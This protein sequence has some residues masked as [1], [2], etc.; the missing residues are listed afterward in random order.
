[1]QI[2]R[3]KV[4]ATR[5]LNEKSQKKLSVAHIDLEAHSFLKITHFVN[6]YLANVLITNSDPIVFTS[7]QAILAT[8]KIA[9]AFGIDLSKRECFCISGKTES[10]ALENSFYVKASARNSEQLSKRI[11]DSDV[12]SV[13]HFTSNITLDEFYKLLINNGIGVIP[14]EVYFKELCEIKVQDKFKGVLFFSPSQI[15][16]FLIK[17]KLDLEIP[18]F[19][20]G[21]STSAYLSR[22]NHKNIITSRNSTEEIL[23]DTVI[24]YYRNT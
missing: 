11:V 14:F 8:I 2:N 18:A 5:I 4:I 6:E 1:V 13:L 10:C 19:C 7:K 20:I 21:E 3:I 15:N 9:L 22:L 16:A 23:I 24:N 17:N 12:K